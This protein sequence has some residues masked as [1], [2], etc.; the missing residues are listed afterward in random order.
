M[1]LKVMPFKWY[2]GKQID[3]IITLY[4]YLLSLS[5]TIFDPPLHLNT[6]ST[7]KVIASPACS[8]QQP[9]YNKPT[10]KV[11]KLLFKFH[12]SLPGTHK[13]SILSPP[14]GDTAHYCV[15]PEICLQRHFP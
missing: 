10:Q 7:C 11:I 9:I 8:S 3:N 13:H 5:S 6:G 4:T 1:A 2:A 12:Q 15:M 14:V